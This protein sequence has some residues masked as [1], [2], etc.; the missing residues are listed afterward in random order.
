[1]T[2]L[3]V[4]QFAGGRTTRLALLL[5]LI[6]V[7][8]TA[9]YVA[10]PW[11]MTPDAF[12]SDLFRELIVPTLLPIV[13]LLPATAAFGNELEDGTIV[14]LLMKPVSRLRLVIGKYAS[15]LLVTIPALIVG[16]A[17]TTLLASRGPAG[18]GLG[19]AFLAMA[20]A[21]ATD[22]V[23]LGAVFLAASLI[24]P[25]ALLAGM[26]YIFLWESL[27]GRFLPGVRAISSRESTLRV[28]DGLLGEDWS[29]VSD[30]AAKMLLVAGVCLLL[31]VWR[32]K[33][34]QVD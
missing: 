31:A 11:R 15:V 5:S 18:E 9:I 29:V 6:P 22:A 2:T 25:R 20:G 28:Y 13:V 19:Q 30:V 12:L 7:L 3:T 33:R 10:R 14:Y 16:L 27:L 4:R 24:V 26:I 17:V 8:F 34:I 32:L 21:A 1:M 23:L